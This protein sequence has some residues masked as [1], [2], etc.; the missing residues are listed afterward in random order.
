MSCVNREVEPGGLSHIPLDNLLS[1]LFSAVGFV[2]P[3]LVTSLPTPVE[4]ASCKIHK[5]LCTGW[6]PTQFRSC[7]RVEVAVLGCPS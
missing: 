2:D 3:V 5:L 6:V 1:L 4:R 7:G